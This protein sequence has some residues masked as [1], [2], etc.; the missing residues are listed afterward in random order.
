MG[1]LS[2]FLRGTALYGSLRL[3]KGL[4]GDRGALYD[5]Q[6]IELLSRILR[7]DSSCVDVGSHRGEVLRH[8]VRLSP[9]GRHHAFEPIPELAR[10]LK[11]RFPDVAVH[12]AALSAAPGRSAFQ[13]VT[14]ASGY[15]GLKRRLYDR[16]DPRIEEIEVDVTTLDAA[17][18][19]D[20]EVAFVKI[21]VEGGEV[22]VL[23]GA[24]ATLGR[25]RPWVLFE[26]GPRSTG[27]YR[28]GPDEIL[29]LLVEGC[30]YRL[31]TMSRWLGGRPPLGPG[32][33][34]GHWEREDEYYFL[35]VP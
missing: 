28:D 11:R 3:L 25:C 12:E 30:G 1:S 6:T 18:G 26:A 32:E 10:R 5:R 24:L 16:P 22:D 15:S 9:R 2:E 29:A 13:H 31:T 23:R 21:D 19:P 8:V 7:P 17:V 34:A 20:T 33:L 4:L 27:Q 14:N 35:A